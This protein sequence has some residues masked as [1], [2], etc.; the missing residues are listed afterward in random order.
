MRR[1]RLGGVGGAI[2][3]RYAFGEIALI[4][5]GIFIA[6]QAS[7]WWDEVAERRLEATYLGELRTELALDREQV[8][9]ALLRYRKISV[10]VEEL[11]RIMRS[12]SSY[13][14]SYDA[15]FGTAYG[16]FEFDLSTA[17][18]ESLKSHG[19]TLISNGPLRS[20]VAQVY[21]DTYPRIRRS[22]SWEASLVLDLMRPYFLVHFRD[23]RFNESATPV[24]YETIA[25]S[26]EFVNLID[27]RLQL[28]RQNHLRVFGQAIDE[29][30]ALIAALDAE[31][32]D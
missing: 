14:D 12:D 25:K 29:I 3:W 2:N 24:D 22:I 13:E 23:L 9:E 10:A 7:A 15:Y 8:E 30:D 26:T 11:L 19:L 21:E 16:A 4:V 18:Y 20:Q 1:P 17:A 31:L 32:A 28:T 6:L 5:I 27:Y